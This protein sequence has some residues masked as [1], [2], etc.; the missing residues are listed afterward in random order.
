ML[1]LTG[2]G[3]RAGD[4]E[5]VAS[6]SWLGS[7]RDDRDCRDGQ[8]LCGVCTQSCETASCAEGP[9]GSRCIE[10]SERGHERFCA[11]RDAPALCLVRCDQDQCDDGFSCR[12]AVCLPNA[13]AALTPE[14]E[15]E[16]SNAADAGGAQLPPFSLCASDTVVWR[17]LFI[18]DQRGYDALEGL[19]RASRSKVSPG[20]AVRACALST[21]PT[22]PSTI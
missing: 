2:C 6:S 22:P 9:P 5:R 8:C 20:S 12:D 3:G 17:S 13:V 10:P 21:S 11:G 16:P 15:P 4:N 18:E 19:P 7:C 14:D 1:A